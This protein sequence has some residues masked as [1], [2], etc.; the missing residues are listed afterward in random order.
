MATF[1]IILISA[2]EAICAIVGGGF[3]LSV[4]F[5][6]PLW[7]GTLIWTALSIALIPLLILVE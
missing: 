2:L 7:I 6:I 1:L 5:T 3:I 4:V